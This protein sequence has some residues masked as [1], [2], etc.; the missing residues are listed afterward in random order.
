VASATATP[1]A[2]IGATA[3]YLG[4]LLAGCDIKGSISIATGESIYQVPGQEYYDVTQI[5]PLKGKRRFCSE[6]EARAAGWR[7]GAFQTT[8][9]EPARSP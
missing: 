7:R 8:V 3:G 9:A 2:H 4:P 6:E 5:D 1:A